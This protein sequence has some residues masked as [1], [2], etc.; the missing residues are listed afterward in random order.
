VDA[1]EYVVRRYGRRR[2]ILLGSLAT[3]DALPLA[4]SYDLVVCSDV[5]QY[6]ANAEIRR[7][8]R[9]LAKRTG[10]VAFIEAFTRADDMIGDRDAWHERS[11]HWYRQ[12]LRD[13]GFT[14][15]GLYLFVASGLRSALNELE[16]C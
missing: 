12:A 10:G 1:S 16:S 6:V 14:S 13:A 2:N 5:L 11:A 7:G 15:V 4:R 3:L 9:A 8:L